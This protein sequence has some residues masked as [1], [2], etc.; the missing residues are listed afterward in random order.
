MREKENL[1]KKNRG[2]KGKGLRV[3]LIDGVI[4]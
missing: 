4:R 2:R 1:S 3:G